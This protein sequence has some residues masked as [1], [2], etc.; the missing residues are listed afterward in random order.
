MNTFNKAVSA[1]PAL[2]QSHH[3]RRDARSRDI[4]DHAIAVQET[5]NTMA[6]VE[7]LKSHDVAAHVIER[8]L[9]EPQHRRTA[10]LV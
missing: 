8:V 4:V 1:A 2:S 9:L 6:A 10:E 5:A 7:Y 3:E